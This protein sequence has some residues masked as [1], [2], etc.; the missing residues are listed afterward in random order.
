MRRLIIS[1]THYQTI[2]AIQLKLTL[3][4]NDDVVLLISDHSNGSKGLSAELKKMGVFEDV[5]YIESKDLVYGYRR[6]QKCIDFFTFTFCKKN[7][8]SYYLNNISDLFFDE[9]LIYNY[10]A[11]IYGLFSHL[12]CF[13]KALHISLFEEGVLSYD[14]RIY[15]SRLTKLSI[16]FRKILF[17]PT[18]E[19]KD[20]YCFYPSLYKKELK[21]I[22]IPFIEKDS[23]L[24]EILVNAFNI[25][26]KNIE[27]KEKY[28]VFTSVYDFEGNSIGEFE[29]VNKLA[30]L[31]GKQNIIVKEHPRDNRD[32][33]R[34]NGFLVDKNS[35]V[36]WEIMHLSLNFDNN[37]FLS[38]TS[39]SVLAGNLMS[40]N[41][42]KSLYL[43]KLCNIDINDAAKRTVEQINLLLDMLQENNQ[44]TPIKTID[45]IEDILNE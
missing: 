11:D 13:N 40:N 10:E 22:Q 31:V 36:P 9:L 39:G 42:V 2:V 24:I 19:N 23:K 43:Y 1:N 16:F 28:I 8:F 17:K 27:Y 20:F 29:L 45:R 15:N 34:K 41:K 33:Y 12:S 3:F 5:L 7:R 18:V 25:D 44:N 26:T 6:I 14:Y 35:S 32:I 4:K 38:I 30:S 37:V 21:T